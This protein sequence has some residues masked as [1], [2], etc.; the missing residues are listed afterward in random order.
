MQAIFICLAHNLMILLEH[1]LQTD[2]GINNQAEINRRVSVRRSPV[3]A[4]AMMAR[5]MLRRRAPVEAQWTPP[6]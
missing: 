6:P 1:R 3:V 4:M 5:K 2:H